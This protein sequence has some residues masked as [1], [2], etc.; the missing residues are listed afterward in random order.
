[1]NFDGFDIFAFVVFAV[2]LAVA[3][4]VIVM[5]GALPGT[6]AAKRGHPYAAAV[7]VAAWISLL[8]LG[9]LWPLALVWAFLPWPSA[10]MTGA[11][12]A[13]EGGRAP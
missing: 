7:N 9:A 8:T 6:I 11:V 12:A 10:H 5:L 4:A 2:L 3:V 1:M 13:K